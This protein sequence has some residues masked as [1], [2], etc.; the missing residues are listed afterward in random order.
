MPAGDREQGGDHAVVQ[1][2]R[3]VVN[4]TH[5]LRMPL[6]LLL[7]HAE[8][9]LG[10]GGLDDDQL[11]ALREMRTGA[12]TV[13]KRV[14]ELLDV[15]RLDDR[16]W[17]AE[18]SDGD[19]AL[20]VRHTAGAFAALA[21]RRGLRWEVRVP[22]SWPARIDE[23]KLSTVV[24]NLLANALKFT[25]PGGV[26]RCSLGP[27]PRGARIEV[28]DSGP[29]V[30]PAERAEVFGRFCQGERPAGAPA[31]S[32][33]GL[34]IARQL[35]ALQ[36][37][38]LWVGDAPEGGAL[39]AIEL[40]APPPTGDR[41]RPSLHEATV[42]ALRHELAADMLAAEL[43]VEERASP[44]MRDG[45]RDGRGRVL[46]I[47]PDEERVGLS[48]LLTPRYALRATG[49]GEMGLHAALTW[50]PDVIV[51]HAGVAAVRDGSFLR[52]LRADATLSAVSVLA[53]IPPHQRELRVALVLAGACDT[54]VTP[55]VPEEVLPR[56]DN[57]VVLAGLR[58]RTEGAHRPQAL[59]RSA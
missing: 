50:R 1:L 23:E 57:L 14:N 15:A 38:D 29:G 21:A 41:R 27:C 22:A 39:F 26:V 47:S 13:L 54:L 58:R 17:R 36:G 20:L 12:L 2:R 30:P 48:E 28:A 43:A 4:D 31:G 55:L 49:D 59:A 46:L 8:R 18:P 33:L 44:A 35:S 52:R 40:P 42:A 11:A 53:V 45:E 25:P 3:R 5:E 16:G 51:A 6:T 19:L 37:A 24:G 10:S 56:V 32:G 9:L 7:C 34:A